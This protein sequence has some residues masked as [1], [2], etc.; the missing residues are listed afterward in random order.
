MMI[1][2][3][4]GMNARHNAGAPAESVFFFSIRFSLIV[5]PKLIRVAFSGFWL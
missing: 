5:S 2:T 4:T 1:I 3:E